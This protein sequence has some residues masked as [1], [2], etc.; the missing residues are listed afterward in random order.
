MT[1]RDTIRYNIHILTDMIATASGLL[2]FHKLNL[3]K[4]ID[5]T[6]DVKTFV[7]EPSSSFS[8]QAGQYGVWFIPKLIMG[9]PARLFT[10]SSSPT[11]P[12]IRITTRISSTDFKRKLVSLPIGH[13]I[14]MNGPIG[15]FT[16]NQHRPNIVMIAG[17]IGITPVRALAVENASRQHKSR[18]TLIYSSSDTYLFQNELKR[19]VDETH[20]TN[21]DHFDR[22]VDDVI[23][24][25]PKNTLYMISGPPAFVTYT[26]NFLRNKGVT[27]IKKDGFLG[28]N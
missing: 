5:E 13:T 11:E 25:C 23:R 10:L 21:R 15:R 7:F 18:L 17:G 8:F 24:L 12:Y 19:L 3:V 20:F 1:I 9:K 26:D 14:Y 4:V 16:L 2:R 22:T 6:D 28:Y 27:N